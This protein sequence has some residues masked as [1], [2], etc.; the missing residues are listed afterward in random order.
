MRAKNM[1]HFRKGLGF[2]S[3]TEDSNYY[4][5]CARV[6]T[7]AAGNPLK[8]VLVFTVLANF[9]IECL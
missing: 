3:K 2:L 8:L 1:L 4:S 5:I 7:H 9:Q 6:F